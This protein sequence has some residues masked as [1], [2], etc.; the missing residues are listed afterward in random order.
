[1]DIALRRMRAED[2]PQVI[3]IEKEAFTPGWV[4]TPFRRELNSRYTRF[5][6]AYHTADADPDTPNR[7]HNRSLQQS[8]PADESLWGRMVTGVRSAL[9][10]RRDR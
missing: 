5:L 9:G 8:G 1:M 10:L 2:I 4:G 3:E 7:G 6:V